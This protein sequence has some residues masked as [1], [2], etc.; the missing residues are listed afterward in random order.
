MLPKKGEPQ[1][2]L[3]T[4]ERQRHFASQKAGSG[5]QPQVV[6]GSERL[7]ELALQGDPSI[8]D[9]ALSEEMQFRPDIINF[10][11]EKNGCVPL[12]VAASKGNIGLIAL[13]IRRNA[14]VNVQD[15]FGNTPLL[16]ALHKRHSQAAKVSVGSLRDL[17][18]VLF[19]MVIIWNNAYLCCSFSF[20][21]MRT[22]NFLI[23][24]EIRPSILPL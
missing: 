22:F 21:A 17:L 18:W 1:P 13:L 14:N 11:E 12:H 3:G 10:P 9:L 20:R 24:E 5:W 4:K 2:L 23:S 7:M 6:Q 15:Y 8:F 16:Y 19:V